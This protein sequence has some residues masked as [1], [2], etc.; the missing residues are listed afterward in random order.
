[1]ETLEP[2]GLQLPAPPPPYSKHFLQLFRTY[3]APKQEFFV[4]RQASLVDH[5]HRILL[6]RVLADA[7]VHLRQGVRVKSGTVGPTPGGHQAGAL[8]LSRERL[9]QQVQ[10]S[11]GR[12]GVALGSKKMFTVLQC[13]VHSLLVD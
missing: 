7:P 2:P 9:L 5:L 12:V 13:A 4:R 6:L 10:A 3:L 1:M 11:R 8:L